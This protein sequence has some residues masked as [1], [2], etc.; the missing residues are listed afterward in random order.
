MLRV[1]NSFIVLVFVLTQ[2]FSVAFVG[3]EPIPTPTEPQLPASPLIITAYQASIDGLDLV[4]IYND[5]DDIL[6][7]NGMNLRYSNKANATVIFSVP[8]DGL[9]RPNSHI[10][11]AA[12][13]VL[14]SSA[15][16][17]VRFMPSGWAPKAVW[18]ESASFAS[19]TL[20]ADVKTD[21][22]IYKRSKTTT[23]Y[24]TAVSALNTAL[25]GN[26]IEADMMY[27]IPPSPALKVVE[28][29][30]RAKT[31]SPFDVDVTCN[32]YV[33][34]EMLPGFDPATAASYRLRTGGS[35]S[36]T[37]DFSL[38]NAS[39][40]NG[41]LLLS[42]RNDNEPMSLSNGGGYI[43]LED[44]Y[45]LVRYGETLVEYADGGSET[46]VNQSWAL[47]DQTASWQWGIPSPF[48][49]NIF[50]EP[51]P[52][53][54]VTLA[55]CPAGKYRNPETNRCRSIEEAVSEL[56]SCEEGKERNPLTNRCRSIITTAAAN[57]SPCEAGQER[58]PLTNRCRQVL[59]A[60]QSLAPCDEGQERSRETNRCR[61]VVAGA[62]NNL[63][64]VE[65][66][67]S[68]SKATS[69]PWLLIGAALLFALGYAI[70][71]WRQEILRIF[72]RP[73]EFV[74]KKNR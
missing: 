63:A 19:V 66:V 56:A 71:E 35:E 48:G 14:A 36:I 24:S 5:S 1:V 2:L 30:A 28:V 15:N 29:L 61:K 27:I 18:L 42:Q 3:A 55:D 33:K 70:Y 52:E 22:V 12:T 16:V 32:D 67:K 53:V 21:G 23:G 69:P 39:V 44:T 65:D 58:N 64:S 74:T 49:E 60:S 47:N 6:S 57:L 31:C 46:Y 10:L 38:A 34:L 50:H 20:P 68:P 40:R 62:S 45:G 13:D 4:Q 8:L 41:Y 9:M 43:W 7:L 11:I 59:A 54:V 51:A 37:N 17:A 25:S 26:S 72:R 73:I